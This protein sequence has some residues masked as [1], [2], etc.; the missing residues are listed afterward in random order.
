MTDECTHP[1][2]RF[3]LVGDVRCVACKRIVV[4]F[5]ARSPQRMSRLLDMSRELDRLTEQVDRLTATLD[6]F[7]AAY[8]RAGS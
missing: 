3:D 7:V 8:D 2:V 4:E 6:R 1:S 5:P